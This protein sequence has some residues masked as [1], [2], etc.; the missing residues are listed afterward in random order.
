MLFGIRSQG[1]NHE[2]AARHNS[3]VQAARFRHAYPERRPRRIRLGLGEGAQLD[4][5]AGQVPTP[6]SRNIHELRRRRL[7]LSLEIVRF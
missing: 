2:Q 1:H 4:R 6:E 7:S 3:R 5:V